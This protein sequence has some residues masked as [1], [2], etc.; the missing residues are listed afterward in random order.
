MSEKKTGVEKRQGIKFDF[1]K[2]RKPEK[3]SEAK[4]LKE[5]EYL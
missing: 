1:T 3:K 2:S 5:F 4:D